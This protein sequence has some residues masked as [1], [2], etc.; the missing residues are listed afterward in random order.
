M[1]L[2]ADALSRKAELAAVS[3]ATFPLVERIKEG[4]TEDVQAKF[5]LELVKQ[6][7]TRRFWLEDGLLYTLQRRL[8]VAGLRKEII[9]EC[10]D[11]GRTSGN[12]S[13]FDA[14]GA[15]LFL[16]TNAQRCGSLCQNLSCVSARQG[17]ASEA[18]GTTGTL[19]HSR[20]SMGEHLNGFYP[21]IAE[22]GMVLSW[23]SWIV[24]ANMECSSH[25]RSCSMLKKRR[26][27]SLKR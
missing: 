3:R 7:K 17:R 15:W 21:R 1:N 27:P 18:H 24:S 11:S 19:T 9:K 13:H 10:H 25:C 2:V 8:F 14:G 22:G 26:R 4:I 6:G 16:A 12:A 23:W 5:L 20:A